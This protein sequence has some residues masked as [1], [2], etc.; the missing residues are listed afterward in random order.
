MEVIVPSFFAPT[1]TH[2]VAATPGP[3]ARSTSSRDSTIFTGRPLF[4]ESTAASGDTRHALFAPKP[5]PT[6]MGI[7]VMARSGRPT[8]FASWARWPN[9]PCVS[10]QTVSVPSAFSQADSASGSI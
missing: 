5:P 1:L 4:F 8:I 10:A 3:V 9:G 6:S 2:T 7:T